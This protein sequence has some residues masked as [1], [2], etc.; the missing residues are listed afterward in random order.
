M[1]VYPSQASMGLWTTPTDL[2]EILIEMMKSYQGMSSRVV[3]EKTAAQVIDLERPYQYWYSNG[4]GYYCFY[5]FNPAAGQG[6]VIMINHENGDKLR[7]EITHSCF[8]AWKWRWGGDLLLIDRLIY[9]G[10]VF[11]A[12]SVFAFILLLGTVLVFRV[13]GPKT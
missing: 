2:A 3:S 6:I 11:L 7:R 12:I 1:D 5:V 4:T 9:K 8:R 10:L 13:S